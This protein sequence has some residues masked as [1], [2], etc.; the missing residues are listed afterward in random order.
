MKFSLLHEA[1][2]VALAVETE[3]DLVFTVGTEDMEED[4]SA[5]TTVVHVVATVATEEDM[6][7]TIVDMDAVVATT[8]I[9]KRVYLFSSRKGIGR[10]G[11]TQGK[12]V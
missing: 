1:E 10:Q 12:K 11:E 7:A 6:V 4:E 9:T 8:T 3:E 5:P 2:F